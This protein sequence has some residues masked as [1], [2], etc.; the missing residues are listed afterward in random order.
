MS[1]RS[2]QELWAHSKDTSSLHNVLKNIPKEEILPY[3]QPE[4]SF[5]IEVETF[6]KHITQK[7]KIKKIEVS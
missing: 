2:C 3:F 4:K 6:C 7:E 1:L 5:K